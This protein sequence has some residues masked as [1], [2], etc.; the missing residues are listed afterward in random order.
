MKQY[1]VHTRFEKLAV[2][3]GRAALVVYAI[4]ALLQGVGGGLA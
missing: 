1:I 4:A 3:A 2:V